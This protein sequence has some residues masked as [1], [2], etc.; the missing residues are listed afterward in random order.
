MK[1]AFVWIGLIVLI[2]IILFITMKSPKASGNVKKNVVRKERPQVKVDAYV[3][4]PVLLINEISVSGS[5]L[6]SEEVDLKN[7]VA[8]RVVDLNLPE[9][10][11]VKKGTLLVKLFDDDLQATLK[12]LESQLDVQEKIYQRQTELYKVNGISENDYEQ[13]CLA[14]NTLKSDIDEQKALIRKTEVVAPFDGVIGLRNVSTGAFVASS[15]LLA[16]IRTEDKIKLDFYVP[17]KYSSGVRQGMKVRFSLS[18]S[19]ILYDATVFATEM[20]INDA[21]R[22][23]KVRAIVDSR[24]ADLVP[25]SFADVKLRLGENANALMIPT[26]A[27][28]PQEESKSVILARKG[29]AHFAVVNTGIRESSAIEITRGLQPGDTVITSGILFLKEGSKLAYSSVTD[30]IR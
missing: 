17:E 20:G 27:I 19:D 3:V 11:S 6:A 15:T 13:T 10:K 28:V 14:V 12:K 23:L 8:G 22:N 7:E 21:T 16:T 30:S 18:N 26:Q 1:K 24:S 2:V 29:R 5:L 25:G 4:K 9:G